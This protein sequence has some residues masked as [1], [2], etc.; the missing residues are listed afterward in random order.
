MRRPCSRGIRCNPRTSTTWTAASSCVAP[1]YNGPLYSAA[2]GGPTSYLNNIKKDWTTGTHNLGG[3]DARMLWALAMGLQMMQKRKSVAGTLST[4]ATFLAKFLENHL[5]RVLRNVTQYDLG[6][7]DNRPASRFLIGY[8]ETYR[9]LYVGDSWGVYSPLLPQTGASAGGSTSSLDDPVAQPTIYVKIDEGINRVVSK[10]F[11]SGDWRN[12]IFIDDS[13]AGDW[14]AWG[15]HQI[16]ALSKAYRL[17]RDMRQAASALDSFLDI[18]T[19]S[20]DTFYGDQG[21]H[22]K[23]STGSY[24]RTNE[25]ITAISGWAESF[26]TNSAQSVDQDSRIVGGLI[27]R[28]GAWEQSTRVDKVPRVAEYRCFAKIV[29]T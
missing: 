19:Y 5:N 6:T 28:A 3:D 22:Y 27:E 7:L 15:Q 18:I 10:Q 29:A 20:A 12:G 23:D 21:Y 1:V 26:Q 8:V 13:T 11:H 24:G 2:T 4:D 9:A 17:K 25:R 16:Y 14:Q